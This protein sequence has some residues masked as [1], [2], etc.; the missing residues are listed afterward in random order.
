MANWLT[1]PLPKEID[2]QLQ[3]TDALSEAEDAIHELRLA[4]GGMEEELA[5]LV[6][7]MLHSVFRG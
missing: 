2:Q 4:F 5:D 7:S 3:L 1:I 6:G